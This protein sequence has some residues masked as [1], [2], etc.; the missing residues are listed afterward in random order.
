[1]Q[2]TCTRIGTR[3]YLRRFDNIPVGGFLTCSDFVTKRPAVRFRVAYWARIGGFIGDNLL[4]SVRP[5]F[6]MLFLLLNH[7]KRDSNSCAVT[8][9]VP[10]KVRGTPQYLRTGYL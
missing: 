8:F 10:E 3:V 7:R 5:K 1:M 2:V 6:A 4:I 9:W